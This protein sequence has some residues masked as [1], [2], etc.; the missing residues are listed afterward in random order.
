MSNKLLVFYVLVRQLDFSEERA[1]PMGMTR[2]LVVGRIRQRGKLQAKAYLSN[3]LL[4]FY[5]QLRQLDCSK[6]ASA[7]YEYN[8]MIVYELYSLLIGR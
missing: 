4:S 8:Q 7:G 6:A 1:L 5:G 3:K 2:Y